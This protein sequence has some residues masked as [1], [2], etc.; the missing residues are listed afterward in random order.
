MRMRGAISGFETAMGIMEPKRSG[1]A[2][3]LGSPGC[4]RTDRALPC[5]HAG[6]PAG[7]RVLPRCPGGGVGAVRVSLKDP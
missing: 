1:T 6:S 4:F 7:S 2:S 3:A 5:L